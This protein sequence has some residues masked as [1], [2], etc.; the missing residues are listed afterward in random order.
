M[1]CNDHA[2]PRHPSPAPDNRP[3][4]ATSKS[5][6]KGVQRHFALEL[7]ATSIYFQFLD[8]SES[9]IF[10]FATDPEPPPLTGVPRRTGEDRFSPTVQGAA[11]PPSGRSRQPRRGRARCASGRPETTTGRPGAAAGF[12]IGQERA[13]HHP[14]P[15]TPLPLARGLSSS[16][17]LY[18]THVST[19]YPHPEQE[20]RL[21][22][23]NSVILS[24]PGIMSPCPSARP[25]D[26]VACSSIRTVNCSQPIRA[27]V[28]SAAAVPGHLRV[29]LAAP[30][31]RG[32]KADR[33]IEVLAGSPR[34]GPRRPSPP[35]PAAGTGAPRGT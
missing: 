34:S 19:L 16:A 5:G 20:R 4:F 29:P 10:S 21:F 2:L 13:G 27:M 31:D 17:L 24:T 30:V 28:W 32:I 1:A 7:C 25:G 8:K 14:R 33:R 3:P 12:I 35:V 22:C 9:S 11:A 6:C 18:R 15:R 26:P 23:R